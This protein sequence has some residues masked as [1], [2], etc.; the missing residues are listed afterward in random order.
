MNKEHTEAYKRFNYALKVG[1][2]KRPASCSRC[3]KKCQP[4]GH[5]QDYDLPLDVQWLCLKCHSLEHAMLGEDSPMAK[6]TTS[7]VVEMRLASAAGCWNG[8]LARRFE[9]SPATVSLIVRGKRWAHIQEGGC[10]S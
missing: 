4:H 10:Q 5:H 1:K 6:L 8:E 2:L 7:Q 9:V 3:G